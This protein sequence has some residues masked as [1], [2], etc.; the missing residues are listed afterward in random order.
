LLCFYNA[1]ERERESPFF[2]FFA[3]GVH[4]FS[5]KGCDAKLILL[6]LL[7]CYF[8]RRLKFF[9]PVGGETSELEMNSWHLE[10]LT[11]SLPSPTLPSSCRPY[12]AHSHIE[13]TGY[14][15]K[16]H[17]ILLYRV[18]YGV[19]AYEGAWGREIQ[20]EESSSND[21]WP[22]TGKQPSQQISEGSTEQ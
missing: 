10:C 4:A 5:C 6:L 21:E 14:K 18:M 7:F 22:F 9:T 8:T 11:D 3:L 19:L 20:R 2:F 13:T 15:Y 17:L 16:S 1:L 12:W